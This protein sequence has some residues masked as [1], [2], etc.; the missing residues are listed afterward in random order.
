MSGRRLVPEI[1]DE[2]E[3]RIQAG[4]AADPDNPEWTDEDFANARP[5]A[6]VYPDW[7][8]QIEEGR[9][10]GFELVG[11]D[12]KIVAKLGTGGRELR[13]RVNDILRKAVGL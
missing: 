9:M 3:A 11:V 5:F 13:D 7:A 4:I 2:E 8:K 10:G 6:E 12:L 1:S